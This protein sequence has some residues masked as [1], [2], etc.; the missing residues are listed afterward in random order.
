M[1]LHTFTYIVFATCVNCFIMFDT[2]VVVVVVVFFFL[3]Q[4]PVVKVKTSLLQFFFP[5][6][7]ERILADI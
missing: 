6:S 5:C 7:A 1:L 2:T 3:P 4:F